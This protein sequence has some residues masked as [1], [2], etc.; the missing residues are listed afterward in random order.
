MDLIIK[1]HP[2]FL[3]PAIN[4]DFLSDPSGFLSRAS[5][6]NA[7]AVRERLN[8]AGRRDISGILWLSTERPQTEN[9]FENMNDPS[10]L[11]GQNLLSR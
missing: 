5:V 3:N 10:F 2:I 9:A 8:D 1:T 11:I 6:V 7:V 4:K